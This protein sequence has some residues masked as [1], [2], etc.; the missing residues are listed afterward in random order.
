MPWLG[1]GSPMSTP[2]GVTKGLREP[3]QAYQRAAMDE[4]SA[5]SRNKGTL[6]PASQLPSPT[7]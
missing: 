5:S 3:A 2:R 4:L 1:T 6:L 7:P